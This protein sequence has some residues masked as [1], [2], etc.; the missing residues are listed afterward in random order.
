MSGS[1]SACGDS[2][3]T[4][5]D[6]MPESHLREAP[7]YG[8]VP[9][10][11]VPGWRERFGVLAGITG[12]GSAEGGF[13]LGLWT[14]TGDP[15]GVVMQRWKGLQ[16]ATAGFTGIVTAHQIHGAEVAWH[17]A[18]QGW[19]LLDGVDGHATGAAGVLLTVTV[20]DCIPVY[21]VDPVG[22]RI[23]LLHAGWRGVAAGILG[24]G[25]NLLQSRGSRI[26]D[27]SMHCGVGICGVCYEVGAEVARACGLA[28]DGAGPCHLDLRAALVA[29][30][31]SGGV[32]DLST[33]QFCSA[34]DSGLFFSHRASRGRDGRMVAYLGVLP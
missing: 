4:S 8:A 15:A 12:R 17:Q 18:V 7:L 14:Q 6:W 19:L 26:R 28:A 10:L 3:R 2:A 29:Q 31:R 9:R 30:A 33:S 25:L 11:E 13:D 27:I 16:A 1:T 32:A 22:R 23:A 5:R 21:L 20:A 24:Q 34:H